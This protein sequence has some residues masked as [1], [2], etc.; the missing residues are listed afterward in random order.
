MRSCL[1]LV[2]AVLLGTVLFAQDL[3]PG[4][5]NVKEGE[6]FVLSNSTKAGP[7]ST[8]MTMEFHVDKIDL[9]A[10]TL[11]YSQTSITKL[12]GMDPIKNTMPPQTVPMTAE[13]AP[14]PSVP[15]P[16]VD[17]PKTDSVD[18]TA[19]GLDG[20]DVT[21]KCTHGK[22][23]ANGVTSEFWFSTDRIDAEVK[24]GDH[25]I[26]V[27]ALYSKSVSDVPG[28][29][30]A[31]A[32]HTVQETWTATDDLPMFSAVL[33]SHSTMEGATPVETTMTLLEIRMP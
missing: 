24:C 8:E 4:Y 14:T 5:K 16:K 11:T 6:V 1:F 20:K 18:L 28:I 15:A 19:K 33:F 31:A 3:L 10:K 25:A 30:G 32:T 17:V 12:P 27:H 7:T 13:P 22:T 9:A 29:G 26:K 21:I 23:E 2:S